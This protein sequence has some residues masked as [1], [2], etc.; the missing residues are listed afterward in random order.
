MINL[1]CQCELEKFNENKKEKLDALM[2]WEK[3]ETLKKEEQ[4]LYV[5]KF[6]A[7]L[8]LRN[9]SCENVQ[10]SAVHKWKIKEILLLFFAIAHLVIYFV[11]RLMRSKCNSANE[12]FRN[13]W[14]DRSE[15]FFL[16]SLDRSYWLLIPFREPF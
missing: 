3:K 16:F 13:F 15:Q 4:V 10:V 6:C 12:I 2:Y 7:F 14:L 1:C 8:S 11:S 5:I 9:V